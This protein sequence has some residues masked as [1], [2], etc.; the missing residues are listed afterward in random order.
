MKGAKLDITAIVSFFL[1]CLE[2]PF[3]PA[4]K[5]TKEYTATWS[6]EGPTY[7]AEGLFH[8]LLN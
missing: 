5:L 7:L 3:F 2:R 6:P 8:W 4:N 1:M